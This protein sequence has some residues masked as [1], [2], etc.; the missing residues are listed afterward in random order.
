MYLE[1][2]AASVRSVRRSYPVPVL[3]IDEFSHINCVRVVGWY[4]RPNDLGTSRACWALLGVCGG[5]F[6][7]VCLFA[8]VL[9]LSV[10]SL[11]VSLFVMGCVVVSVLVGQGRLSFG[12]RLPLWYALVP[13]LSSVVG[14][15][16][17]PLG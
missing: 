8:F 4:P 10:L 5:V 15:L 17:S 1:G 13:C 9:L 2:I 16:L 14:W 6:M 11:S 12:P 7:F 3:S